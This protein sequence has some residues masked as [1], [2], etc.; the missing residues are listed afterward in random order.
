MTRRHAHDSTGIS[1]CKDNLDDRPMSGVTDEA[2]TLT[3][4]QEQGGWKLLSSTA[5]PPRAGAATGWTRCRPAWSVIEGFAM[6]DPVPV[7]A[8]PCRWARPRP[9]TS[10][11]RRATVTHRNLFVSDPAYMPHGRS[12]RSPRGSNPAIQQ[13]TPQHSFEF[14]TLSSQF[15]TRVLQS[16][17]LEGVGRRFTTSEMA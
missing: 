5:R 7:V 15:C 8:R 17:T 10:H 13:S 11:S 9:A 12:S 1:G 14:R 4:Q 16:P 2:N 3:D 6:F